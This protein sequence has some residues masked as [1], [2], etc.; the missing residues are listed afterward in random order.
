LTVTEAAPPA[1]SPSPSSTFVGEPTPT[2]SPSETPYVRRDYSAPLDDD[3]YEHQWNLRK[4]QAQE[5]W[6]YEGANTTGYGIIISDVDSGLDLS[7]PDFDCPEKIILEPGAN[8]ARGEDDVE[9]NNGHGTHVQGI[10]AACTANGEGIAGV[11]PDA[12]L[13]PVKWDEYT[14]SDV[15]FLM[16]AGIDQAMA[17]GILF[18]TNNGAHVINLSIGDIPPFSHMGPDGYPKTEDAMQAAREAGVVI[19]A[20][21]G[22]FTQP[23]CEFPSLSRNVICAVSTDRNDERVDYS[24]LAVNVD[25]ND[26]EGG[27][28]PV[29]AAPG[30]GGY[31]DQTK[32]IVGIFEPDL[33]GPA[34]NYQVLSTYWRAAPAGDRFCSEGEGYEWLSGT[35]MAAPHVAG[36]AALLYD[37]L[38]GVRSKANADLIVQTIIDTADD[39]GAPGYDPMFGYGRLNALRAVQATTPPAA[40]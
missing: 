8:T 12:Q 4:I 28:Q 18:A 38:G 34:C 11:A 13:L 23:T 29:V 24:D 7:H 32:E 1:P 15:E 21:A 37:R 3:L 5:A 25:K 40:I 14:E 10:A 27:I 39:L 22:N 20:A 31:T 36:V 16:R 30:G 6:N 19:A 2:P 26:V 35:S 9:D 17:D 33:G